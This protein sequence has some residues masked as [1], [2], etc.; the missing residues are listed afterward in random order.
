[1]NRGVPATLAAILVKQIY[2]YIYTYI[3]HISCTCKVW[4][5]HQGHERGASRCASDLNAS[6]W[7]ITHVDGRDAW[8]LLGIPFDRTSKK[9]DKAQPGRYLTRNDYDG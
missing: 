5:S 3:M 6:R 8:A 4:Q 2:I 9:K 7:P 1:M